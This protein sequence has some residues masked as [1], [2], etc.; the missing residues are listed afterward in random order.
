MPRRLSRLDLAALTAM[1]VFAA[2]AHNSHVLIIAGVM[3]AGAGLWL[4]RSALRLGDADPR[5]ALGVGGA[6]I[7]CGVAGAMLFSAMVRHSVGAAPITPPFL[8][9]RVVADG[10]G[11]LY[12]REH[13]WDHPFAVCAFA[14][15]LAGTDTDGFLWDENPR[16]GVFAVA[17][18]EQRRALA[19]EQGR[20]ALASTLAIIRGCRPRPRRGTWRC[21]WCRPISTTSTTSPTCWRSCAPI[22][23]P[24]PPRARLE[25]SLAARR[26]WPISARSGPS[27]RW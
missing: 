17:T 11:R 10:P 19:T 23:R 16:T 12:V 5:P 15:R 25:A 4:G 20:F 14:D 26:G 13:C 8:T 1:T 9:A 21:S 6:A 18:P 22:C 3:A 24:S 27:R 7:A 2:M